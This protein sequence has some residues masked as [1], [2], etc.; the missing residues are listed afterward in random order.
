LPKKIPEENM[1]TIYGVRIRIRSK[2]VQIR[3]T[4]RQYNIKYSVADQ[5]DF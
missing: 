1:P 4:A 2:I 5:D 3:N